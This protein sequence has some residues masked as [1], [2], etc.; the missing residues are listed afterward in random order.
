[1]KNPANRKR[2]APKARSNHTFPDTLG[3]VPIVV[4]SLRCVGGARPGPYTKGGVRQRKGRAPSIPQAASSFFDPM[5]N[6][7]LAGILG[8]FLVRRGLR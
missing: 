2:R 6:A 1:M 8:A 4:R 5:L 3:K 7:G